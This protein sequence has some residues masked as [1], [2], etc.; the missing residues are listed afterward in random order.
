MIISF[1]QKIVLLIKKMSLNSFLG[2]AIAMKGVVNSNLDID[3][4]RRM[5]AETALTSTPQ[6][7]YNEAVLSYESTSEEIVD[8]KK[9]EEFLERSNVRHQ[10]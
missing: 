6:K 8:R 1:L 3:S 4:Y 9:L 2:N 10:F 5:C 7:R